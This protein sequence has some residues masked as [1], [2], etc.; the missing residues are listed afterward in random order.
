MAAVTTQMI[1]AFKE[2]WHRADEQ[3]LAGARVAMGLAAALALA[4]LHDPS[5]D[6]AAEVRQVAECLRAAYPEDVFRELTAED[7]RKI[8]EAL[9]PLGITYDRVGASLMRH[10][11][12]VLDE[13]ARA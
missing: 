9:A 10:T 8:H 11:A 6:S 7:H 5:A 1:Q 2:A 13:L 3:G 4:D 12:N